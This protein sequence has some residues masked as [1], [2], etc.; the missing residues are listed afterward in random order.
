M[1]YIKYLPIDTLK[2]DASFIKDVHT[3]EES[4]A[5]VKAVLT[6]ANTIGLNVIAEGIEIREHVKELSEDG[7]LF[8][9]GFYFSRPLKGKDFKSYIE[10]SMEKI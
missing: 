3:N 5:I 1:S 8:G 4:K 7:L 2:V 10:E 9:Q 6:L